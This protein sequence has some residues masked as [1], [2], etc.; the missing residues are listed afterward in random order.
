MGILIG[1]AGHQGGAGKTTTVL[2]LGVSLAQ[3]G[4]KTLLIDTDP[5]GSLAPA[6]SLTASTEPGLVQ[7]I[8]GQESNQVIKESSLGIPLSLLANGVQQP[9]DA[10]FLEKL[11]KKGGLGRLLDR[12]AQEY[13]YILI[14]TPSSIEAISSM[15]FA[16]CNSVI[17]ILPCQSNAIKTLPGMLRLLTRVQDKL[18]P[19][20]SVLGILASLLDQQNPYELDVL[21]T[22]RTSFPTGIFFSTL[23]PRSRQFEKAASN[24]TSI[25]LLPSSSGITEL[26]THLAQEVISRSTSTEPGGNNDA[27]PKRLF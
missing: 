4:K 16:H 8:R 24:G 17:I 15:V 5:L 11:A 14:D 7:M 3:Q 21:A 20:L 26:Y 18:N 9:G 12:L 19:E 2:N 27:Q 23:I 25:K 1:M 10:F 13:D 6:S 22:I